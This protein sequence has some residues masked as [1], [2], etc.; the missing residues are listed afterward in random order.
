MHSCIFES[1]VPVLLRHKQLQKDYKNISL[2]PL[3]S[4]P[5]IGNIPQ[6]DKQ[7][8][9]FF[10][11]LCRL[12]KQSQDEGKGLFCIWLG[13]T[14]RIF[15]CSGQGLESFI[16][17]SK[18]LVKSFHYTFLEPWLHTGLLTSNNDKW[19]SRR[20]L[21]TPSF[22]DTQLLYN[23]MN[24]F[25]EQSYILV[26]RFDEYA[27]QENRTHDLYP[28]I[29]ACTLDIIAEAAMGT[30]PNAQL[31]DDK[32]EFV[33]ATARITS[34]VATRSRCPWLW[35]TCIF[36]RIPIGKE[37]KRVLEILHGFS[38]KVI[39]E[40]L[41]TFNSEDVVNKNEEKKQIR[42]LVFL[43]SL[44]AQMHAEKLSFDDIQ[45]EADTFMFEGHDTTAAAIN[46]CCYLVGCHQD[47][48]EKIHAEMDTIFGDDKERACTMEDIQQMTYLD[49]VIKESLRLLPSVAHVSREAQEDF[50]YHGQTIRKGTNVVIFI[51]GIHH[52]ENVFPNPEKFD[53]ERFSDKNLISTEISPFAY[54]P[55][56]A[57]SRNCVGQR[58]AGLEERV[59][60]STLFRRFTF[61]ST[62]TIDELHIATEGILR[63]GV[64]VQMIVKR[65]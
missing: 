23:F 25:N 44:I 19:R 8:H 11:L 32:N 40:R 65:R 16:N 30:N 12:A 1:E 41:A 27:K 61:H 2:L 17:N 20:R 52:D 36:D 26:R 55:F 54:I 63:P 33:Q 5:L 13:I 3:S 51:Y 31:N 53:P 45:E 10:Q 59:V 42:R 22:H 60:L 6:F 38:R 46:Y 49:C 39:Q 62:Q 57:G 37:Q 15:L 56:S 58:F 35:P 9:V 34:I 18:Q 4:I 7:H 43:D 14:P 48:Q 21:I 24:I 50:V 47:V 29:S 28:Y 64:P